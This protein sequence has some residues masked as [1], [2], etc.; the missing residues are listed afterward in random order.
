VLLLRQRGAIVGEGYRCEGPPIKVRGEGQLIIGQN[1]R[2][3]TIQGPI[4]IAIKP[5]ATVVIRDGAFINSGVSIVCQTYIEI[6]EDSGI[7][8]NAMVWD[9]DLHEV[10]EGAGIKTKRIK[11]GRNVWIGRGATVL[12]GVTIGDHSVAA[13]AAVVTKPVPARQVVAGNPAQIVREVRAS[14]GFKRL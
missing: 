5:G 6:G 1:V 11:L 9:T 12:R 10:D 13:A 8:E 4:S 14:E 2:F 3:R 7:A